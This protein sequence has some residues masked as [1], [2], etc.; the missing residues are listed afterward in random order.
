MIV[1]DIIIIII[2]IKGGKVRG[3]ETNFAQGCR[4]AIFTLVYRKHH[5]RFRLTQARTVS[6]LNKRPFSMK[7]R[8][9]P[10]GPAGVAGGAGR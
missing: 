4:V 2:I 3:D 10:A 8:E 6:G 1:I 9:K 7:I 5:P